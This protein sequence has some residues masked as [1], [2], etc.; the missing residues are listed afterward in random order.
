MATPLKV[1]DRAPTFELPSQS[2]DVV[3]LDALTTRGPVVLYFYPKDETPGCTAEACAFRDNY[4]VFQKAGASVVGISSD[5]VTSHKG[6]AEHHGLPFLLLSDA[7]GQ[8][9]KSFGVPSTLGLLP[10]RMTFVIDQQGVI[11]HAFNSQLF[12]TKH[13]REAIEVV[14]KLAKA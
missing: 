8:V 5:S 1:G 3:K 6:F 14:Q 4:D 2:G 11:Q 9:R 12:A 7:S 10:G 13:V